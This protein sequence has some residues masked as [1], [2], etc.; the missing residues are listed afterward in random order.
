MYDFGT[1]ENLNVRNMEVKSESEQ[2][3]DCSSE[4]YNP[5]FHFQGKVGPPLSPAK[6]NARKLEIMHQNILKKNCQTISD[7]EGWTT[8]F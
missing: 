6:L 7:E 2:D 1:S 8:D 3:E 5:D 4:D